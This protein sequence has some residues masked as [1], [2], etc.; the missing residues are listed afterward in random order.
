[1]CVLLCLSNRARTI[2]TNHA[3]ET[4]PVL[5]L[6]GPAQTVK[7]SQS[8]GTTSHLWTNVVHHGAQNKDMGEIG[9]IVEGGERCHPRHASSHASS[10]AHCQEVENF[11]RPRHR[12]PRGQRQRGRASFRAGVLP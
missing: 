3:R 4:P 6:L 7:Q 8:C 2:P 11:K 5:R 10:E 12:S 1:V 9:C